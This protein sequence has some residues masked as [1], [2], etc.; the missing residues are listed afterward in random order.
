MKLTK[1]SKRFLL[2]SWGLALGAFV[3][4]G[5]KAF[6]PHHRWVA[7]G[8]CG[9]SVVSFF[10]SLQRRRAL[11]R[12]TRFRLKTF[13]S[14]YGWHAV[15]GAV[16]L[17]LL[18][19]LNTLTPFTN[20]PLI[21]MT[22]GELQ[23]EIEAD[24]T[25][26]QYLRHSFNEETARLLQ[27]V[28]TF[29]EETLLSGSDKELWQQEWARWIDQLIDLELLKKKYSGFY[30]IDYV[31]QPNQHVDGFS[32]T[33]SLFCCQYANVFRLQR[34][35]ARREAVIKALNEAHSGLGINP[36]VY[37]YLVNQLT[38]PKNVLRL[39]AG[40]AYVKLVEKELKER[41]GAHDS[42]KGDLAF[43]DQHILKTARLV[44]R[45]PLAR[46]ERAATQAFFP[47]QKSVALQ[48]GYLRV[49][50]RPYAIRPEHLEPHI[51]KL[52]P[53]DILLERRNWH[54]SNAGIP[55]FWPHAALYTGTLKDLD[56]F[57][58][59]VSALKGVLFSA[60]L[61]ATYPDIFKAYHQSDIKGFPMRIIEAK[62]PTIRLFSIEESAN[63]D[64]SGSLANFLYEG[65]VISRYHGEFSTLW[66]TVRF[67]F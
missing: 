60:H 18:Y 61:D 40:R 13:F 46:L 54:I 32:I 41:S 2:L 12:K 64:F 31:A 4:I 3:V 43:L 26:A 10:L 15:L 47:I 27:V 14:A 49:S 5:I 38:H 44:I 66:K 58:V 28:E 8:L 11:A 45:N 53:G 22:P 42:I 16:L 7:I 63:C 34:V 25:A 37:D 35:C 24:R 51:E 39:N 23:V 17:S 20:S 9:F 57:F 33:Y 6:A 36:G 52:Q 29:P 21:S 50:D 59:G 65:R 62:T 1:I 48:M 56:D 55:G 30:Q 67:Q 19:G